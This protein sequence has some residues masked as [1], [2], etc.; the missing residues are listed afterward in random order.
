MIAYTT[1]RD[2]T[3]GRGP[4]RLLRGRRT[5]DGVGARARARDGREVGRRRQGTTTRG[6]KKTDEGADEKTD[7]GIDEKVDEGADKGAAARAE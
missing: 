4:G 2:A 7:E 5:G 6:T 3:L 1:S